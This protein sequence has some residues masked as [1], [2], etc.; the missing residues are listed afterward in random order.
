[1]TVWNKKKG[2]IFIVILVN[3]LPNKKKIIYFFLL[4]Q[5]INMLYIYL[6]I[7]N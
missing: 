6:L 4:T 5:Y 1:M 2:K 7:V 3:M